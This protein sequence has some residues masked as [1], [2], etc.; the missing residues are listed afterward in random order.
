MGFRL[1]VGLH[2]VNVST[3]KAFPF[4]EYLFDKIRALGNR[5]MPV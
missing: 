3:L 1:A 5:L 4:E 2:V